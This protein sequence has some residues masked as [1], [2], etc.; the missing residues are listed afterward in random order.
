MPD[1][2]STAYFLPGAY[3]DGDLIY[4]PAHLT[5][6]FVYLSPYVDST[7]Y[8]RYLLADEA[9]RPAPDGH[10]MNDFAEKL[11]RYGWSEERVLYKVDGVPTGKYIYAGGVHQGYF[12]QD[13]LANGGKK[14]LLSWT[15]PTGERPGAMASE[16]SHVTAVVE[17]E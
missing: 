15:V 17:L 2:S 1:A 6:I 11:V 13:D 12:D 9:I 10:P 14:L 7:F 5:F 3:M 16:Y 4:S 8:F